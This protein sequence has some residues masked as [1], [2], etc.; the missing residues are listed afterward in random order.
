MESIK[1]FFQGSQQSFALLANQVRQRG[2]LRSLW[3]RCI[4]RHRGEELR[5]SQGE[6]GKR[7]AGLQGGL[8][9]SGNAPG[10]SRP[11]THQNKRSP[12]RPVCGIPGEH[13]SGKALLAVT[14]GTGKSDGEAIEDKCSWGRLR[15]G[16]ER[17]YRSGNPLSVSALCSYILKSDYL[18]SEYQS[19][20]DG[21]ACAI[22]HF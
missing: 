18:N 7:A 11:G 19:S 12:L 4:L 5:P 16:K 8:P 13:G 20:I 22:M 1:R 21:V 17:G 6:H 9:R 15:G 3:P 14:Y 2:R 10:L